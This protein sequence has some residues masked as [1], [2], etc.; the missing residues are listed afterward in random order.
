[1]GKNPHEK[2]FKMELKEQHSASK[3][4]KKKKK[5]YTRSENLLSLFI[6]P[7]NSNFKF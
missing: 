3:K 7:S 1:M 4:K 6:T 2:I 5:L